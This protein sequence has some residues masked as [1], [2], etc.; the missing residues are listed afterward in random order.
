MDNPTQIKNL[1]QAYFDA[2]YDVDIDVLS[3]FFHDDMHVYGHDEA[4]NLRA[5]NK[6]ELLEILSLFK[7]HHENPRYVRHDEVLSVDFISENAAVARVS[8]RFDDSICTDIINLIRLSG[9]WFIISILD[10][11]VPIPMN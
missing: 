5:A 4:G 2:F 6:S 8:L 10:S 1:L 7:M 9:E 11:R 3:S